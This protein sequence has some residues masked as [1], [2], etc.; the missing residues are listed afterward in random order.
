[1][2]V[3][4]NGEDAGGAIDS[5]DGTL[6]VAEGA[7]FNHSLAEFGSED[8]GTFSVVGSAAH[9]PFLIEALLIASI[10]AVQDEYGVSPNV[11][12]DWDAELERVLSR[13]P[14]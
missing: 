2:L 11:V 10:Q 8:F 6:T 4:P 12:R 7:L 14:R 13:V 9:N 1:M 3:D 5:R